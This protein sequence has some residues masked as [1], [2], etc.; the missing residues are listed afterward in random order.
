[1]HGSNLS[2]SYSVWQEIFRL[3][4]SSGHLENESTGGAVY[5]TIDRAVPLTERDGSFLYSEGPANP[6]YECIDVE[7]DSFSDPLYS[8]VL[9]A[10]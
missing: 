7:S 6:T 3:P 9:F 5:S 8:K 10:A 2:L 1:M 4:Q